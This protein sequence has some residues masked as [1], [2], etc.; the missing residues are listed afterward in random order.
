MQQLPTTHH[1]AAGPPA[2]A[3][4]RR[5][6]EDLYNYVGVV[7]R[8]W[9]FIVIGVAVALTAAGLHLARYK[10]QY[11]GS[12]RLLVIQQ[13]GR[14]IQV[15]GADLFQG[16]QGSNDSL[17]TH[18]LIIR[19]PKIVEEAIAGSGLTTVSVESVLKDLTV[20]VP[21]PTARVLELTY[22]AGSADEATRI[23]DGV[24]KS[25]NDFLRNNYQKNTNAVIELISK[26]RDE[27]SRELTALNRQYVDYRQTHPAFSADKEGR[28]FIARRLD[29]WDQQMNS[30]LAQS[31][32]LKSQL[33]LGKK[34]SQEGVDQAVL[35]NAL[36][37]IGVIGGGAPLAPPVAA[38]PGG[39]REQSYN[40]LA[41]EL[42]DLESR[43]RTAEL[44]VA[45]LRT[46][47]ESGRGAGAVPEAD[48]ARAFY[49]DPQVAGVQTRLRE[50]Q[51]KL[52][53]T[54]RLT[55]SGS[56][57]SVV[58]LRQRAKALKEE[59]DAL[60]QERRGSIAA[61]LA[62]DANPDVA[63]TV[64][65]AEG[66]LIALKAR[67]AALRERVAQVAA[68]QVA[69]LRRE[70]ERLLARHGAGHPQL[71][72]LDQQLA[73]FEEA[74]GRPAEPRRAEGKNEALLD[75]IARSLES[76]ESMRN[77]LQKKFDED[78]AS[79]KKTEISQLEEASL[80]KNMERQETLFNSVV[81][82]LKQAR[83]VSDFGSVSAQVIAPTSVGAERPKALPVF[84]I[85]L[86][87]GCGLGTF[88]AFV[89]DLLDAR[90]RTLAEIRRL[91]DLPVIGLIPQLNGELAKSSGAVGLLSHETPRS[92]LAESYKSTRTNLEFLRRNRPQAQVLLISSPH[93]GDGK[94]TTASNLAITLAN[95]GRRVLLIDGDLRKPSLHGIY[96]LPRDRGFSDALEGAAP[97][98]RLTLPTVVS[99][100]DLLTTGPDV[101]NPAELLASDRLAETVVAVRAHYDTVIIDSSPLLAVTDPSIIAAVADGLVLVVRVSTTRRHDIDRT[102]ELIRTLGVPVLG[103]VV[104]G[105]TR[106]QMGY[107]Y[108][109]GRY[110][111]GYGY[112]YGHGYGYGQNGQ[113]DGAGSASVGRG[114]SSPSK[115]RLG[116]DGG[117]PAA[118]D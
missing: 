59:V 31:L 41:A 94:S 85:A 35:A 2:P 91:I 86:L 68:E 43:R 114:A 81:D 99:N 113:A 27:L 34:L 63:D 20:R 61:A 33:E 11:R 4:S 25:Y 77:D 53:S 46:E 101:A 52:H 39:E 26:A 44:V 38:A 3:D 28:T 16:L 51:T 69:R 87:G 111:Y 18:L 5:I 7:R 23:V 50:A 40:S 10:T 70:R 54:E 79:A 8:G 88:A 37:Q 82:Q 115:D 19:S 6:V 109:G 24:V 71:A 78:V 14:P 100:L 83:L 73:R 22:V 106:E 95:T 17:A 55:R 112:G 118:G 48:V 47:Q 116:L 66:E 98:E 102:T 12:A 105:V 107:P 104:N 58:A 21:D 13:G 30:V 15:S 90:V 72:Q 60:W 108:Y 49:A 64:R 76:I 93:P 65:K 1:P 56:D 62:A 9:R 42:A 36:N 32:R 75:S 92:P 29:Q 96:N 103:M 67:E 84:L 117:P 97:V 74:R 110:G 45:H 57:P 89:A 80:R